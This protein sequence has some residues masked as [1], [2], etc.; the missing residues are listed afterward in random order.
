EDPSRRRADTLELRQML[1]HDRLY[2]ERLAEVLVGHV[3]G[4]DEDATHLVHLCVNELLQ[5]TFEHAGSPEGAFVHC[6][7][8]KKDGNVRIAVADGGI[9]IP[10]A[11]RRSVPSLHREADAAVIEAAV[12]RAGLTS[13]N[14]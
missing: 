8:Y 14:H 3:R 5:N 9:G 1:V 13:T 2:T 10:E 12:T 4:Y 7:W 6:R 11:L